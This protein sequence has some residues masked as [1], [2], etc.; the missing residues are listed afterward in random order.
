MSKHVAVYVR[1]SS[2]AQDHRSQLPD[3]ERW[4]KDQDEPVKWYEDKWTGKTMNRP[5]WNQV[6]EAMRGG[7]I[8]KV[9]TWR[10]DRLGRT[11]VGLCRLFEKLQ[12]QKIDLISLRDG[13]ELN[14][15]AGRH[16]ARMMASNAEFENESRSERIRAGQS[17]AKAKGK[18][19]G[20]SKKGKRKK[21]TETQIRIVHQ[22]KEQGEA[23]TEIARA[24]GLSRP[25]IYEVLR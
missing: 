14:S 2:K 23:V 25:T 5:G 3:L 17:A 8:S 13:F 7:R 22:M 11:T 18:R 19:W 10:I 21:V 20:G 9:V 16:F 4:V 24:V 1:V 6:E 12:T 15:P